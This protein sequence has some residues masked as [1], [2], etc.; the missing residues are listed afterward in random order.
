MEETRTAKPSVVLENSEFRFLSEAG[1]D[2]GDCFYTIVHVQQVLKVSLKCVCS[3]C[4]GTISG[5]KCVQSSC[6]K[7]LLTRFIARAR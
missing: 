7:T 6:S 1:T 3:L 2:P 4:N 5:G